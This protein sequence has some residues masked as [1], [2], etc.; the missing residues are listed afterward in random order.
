MESLTENRALY[1][2]LLYTMGLMLILA[3]EMLPPLNEF[4][5]LH[6]L[7]SEEFKLLLLALL[8]FDVASTYFYAKLLRKIFANKPSAEQMRDAGLLTDEQQRLKKTQ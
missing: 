8:L 1:K 7:P 6:P 4:L 2:C 5:E 3:S